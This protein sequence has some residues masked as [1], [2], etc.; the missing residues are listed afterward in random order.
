MSRIRSSGQPVSAATANTWAARN[1]GS[2]Q[3]GLFSADAPHGFDL[4]GF[5]FPALFFEAL[6]RGLEV[7]RGEAAAEDQ[8]GFA[9]GL[10]VEGGPLEDFGVV[11]RGFRLVVEVLQQILRIPDGHIKPFS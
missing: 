9:E 8:G 5:E 6:E 4:G 3:G 10:I 2:S 11:R 1:P 7:G